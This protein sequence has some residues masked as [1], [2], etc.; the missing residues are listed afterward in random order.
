[1]HNS[2][3]RLFS[4]CAKNLSPSSAGS[5]LKALAGLALAA[6]ASLLMS[7]V[8]S[9]QTPTPIPVTVSLPTA[10]FDTSVPIST[11]IPE[12]VAAT[13]ID[14][15]FNL[16]GFQ[17]DFT[18]DETV[19]TFSAPPVQN[20]GLTAGNWNV[21]GN[22]L[23]GPGP[24]R[25]L[26]VSAFSNDFT[27]LSGSG[28]LYLMRMLR[29][30]GTPGASTPLAWAA[31]PNNF[32]FID[33]NLN[34]VTPSQSNGLITITGPAGTPSPTPSASPTATHTPTPT[35]TATHT[36]TPTPTA[37]HTPTPTATATFTPTATATHTPT[38]TATATAT[39][40][41]TPTPTATATATGTATHTPTATATATAT[42]TPTH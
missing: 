16:V 7:G 6:T 18:F 29:V 36:P 20:S 5:G 39:A 31:K 15:S 38:P 11:V 3:T 35:P 1:M 37:T 40:T 28:T 24:I 12:P 32:F 21:T 14:A 19:A 10:T 2:S 25:T 34:T 41:H 33:S 42:E 30:S 22:V 26:R 13:N 8:A 23:P 17:G 27:P 4:T 9:A